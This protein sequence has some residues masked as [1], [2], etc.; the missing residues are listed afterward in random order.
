M[1][2]P[3]P[4]RPGLLVRDPYHY[5]EAALII[6]PALVR[7]LEFF[8]GQHTEL[9][10]KA[11]LVRI[12]GDLEIGDVVAH[13]VDTLN[14]AGFLENEAF[15]SMRDQRKREFAETAKRPP[16]HAGGAYPNE[17]EPLRATLARY[18]S[19]PEDGA[20]RDGLIGIAAPHVS[21]EGG[22]SRGGGASRDG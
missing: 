11:L 1:A 8:D 14:T 2:S 19:V 3:V 17:V 5:S 12:T 7:C 15:E 20:S 13:L 18:M 22:G 6:P 9:D 10:L 4:D 21:P 16:V